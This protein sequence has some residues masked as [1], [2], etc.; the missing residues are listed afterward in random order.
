[1]AIYRLGQLRYDLAK[2]RAKGLVLKVPKTQTYRVTPHGM[3]ICVL[4]LKLAH[5]VYAPF[6]AAALRPLAHDAM[7]AAHSSMPC[8]PELTA[9]SISSSTTSASSSSPEFMPTPAD[10][11]QNK[12]VPLSHI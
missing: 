5:R 6:A 11:S 8:T 2:L 10:A 9:P 4:F 12:R 3:R 7:L 1:V